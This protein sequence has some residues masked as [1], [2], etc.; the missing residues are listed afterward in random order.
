MVID[1]GNVWMHVAHAK[2]HVFRS[3]CC[4]PIVYIW[5]RVFFPFESWS[6]LLEGHSFNLRGFPTGLIY[7]DLS[8]FVEAP[9]ISCEAE[10]EEPLCIWP[11]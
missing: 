11:P 2:R 3:C 10:F 8:T 1:P 5:K 9:T 4:I 7:P 6:F